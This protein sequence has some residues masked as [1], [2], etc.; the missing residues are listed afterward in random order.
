MAHRDSAVMA[1]RSVAIAALADSSVKSRASSAVAP[2]AARG[3]QRET[4]VDVRS[5]ERTLNEPL[6]LT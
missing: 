6:E 3:T 4:N 2:L 5:L 1:N